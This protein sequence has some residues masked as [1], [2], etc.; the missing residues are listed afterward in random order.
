M[1]IKPLVIDIVI[2]HLDTILAVISI[3]SIPHLSLL[4]L[5]LHLA[6]RVMPYL[7]TKS[8][9]AHQSPIRFDSQQ[10]ATSLRQWGIAVL[11]QAVSEEDI[12]RLQ[13]AF[14]V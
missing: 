3:L 11:R 8:S 14:H 2:V 13:E 5:L 10:I 6:G 4:L 1:M 7:I 9:G 12:H